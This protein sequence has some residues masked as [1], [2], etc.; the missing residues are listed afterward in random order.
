[1]GPPGGEN[2]W[3]VLAARQHGRE[4]FGRGTGRS[5]SDSLRILKEHIKNM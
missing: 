1:M 4:G 2:F 5:C 3:G